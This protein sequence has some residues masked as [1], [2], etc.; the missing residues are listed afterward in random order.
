MIMLI[1]NHDINNSWMDGR[2][3]NLKS[4]GIDNATNGYLKIL[5][6]EHDR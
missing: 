2:E 6:G 5:W 4:E 3:V 1:T